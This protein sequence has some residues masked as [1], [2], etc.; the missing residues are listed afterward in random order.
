[1]GRLPFLRS[2]RFY[3][4][5]YPK[6]A[7]EPYDSG[8]R[9]PDDHERL[10]IFY[11]V[12]D[13]I[14]RFGGCYPALWAA[15]LDF[16]C[17]PRALVLHVC[18]PGGGYGFVRGRPHQDGTQTGVR[19]SLALV[20]LIALLALALAPLFSSVETSPHRA[21]RGAEGKHFGASSAQ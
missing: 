6:F 12:T 15:F 4:S 1:M 14:R 18:L 20:A 13:I 8:L 9:A 16:R 2:R 21:D 5:H 19:V 11:A 7:A 10:I 3:E 17:L